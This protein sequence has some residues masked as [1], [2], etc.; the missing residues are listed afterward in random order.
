M[1][2]SIPSVP[3]PTEPL[4]VYAVVPFAAMLLAIAV[5]PLWIPH[6]WE[7]NRNKL[8]LACALGLPVVGLYAA[9]HPHVLLETAEEYVSF[10]LLLTA[11][12][13]IA[14]GI[15]LTGD[16]RGDAARQHDVPGHRQRPRFLPRHHRGVDAPDPPGPPDQ[17]PADARHAHRRL[18]HLPGRQ[19]RRAP[20]P[21]R[22]PAALPR[23]SRGRPLHLDLPA[24]AALA[25]HRG[26][27]AARV[28]RLGL[29]RV[30]AGAGPGGGP[31][32]RAAAA[33]PARRGRST[34]CGSRAC[35]SAWRSFTPPGGRR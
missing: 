5:C 18:L 26:R 20:D 19:R 32:Q 6:W 17:P 23:L 1:G 30:R 33:A 2:A 22:G 11:L 29:G 10:M 28:L 12:Y 31:R 3:V 8:V 14:G 35:C 16:L 21:A 15:R 25:V 9:R 4:P 34:S 24:P 7:S 27:P 13:V